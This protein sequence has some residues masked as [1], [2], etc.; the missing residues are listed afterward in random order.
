MVEDLLVTDLAD[1][2]TD[3][4]LAP[5]GEAAL[6][7]AAGSWLLVPTET[8]T[9]GRLTTEYRSTLLS[10]RGSRACSAYN[11]AQAPD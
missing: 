6:K 7:D 10:E 4:R 8:A 9:A 1:L 11:P 5:A 2:V 3:S